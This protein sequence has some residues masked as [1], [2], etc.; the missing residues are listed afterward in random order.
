ML[1]NRSIQDQKQL[2]EITAEAVR[3]VLT[4]RFAVINLFNESV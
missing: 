4:V 3:P 1:E 2:T